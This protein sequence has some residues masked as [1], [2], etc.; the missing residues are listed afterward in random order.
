MASDNENGKT[1]DFRWE[2]LVA[3]LLHPVQVEIIEALWWIDRPL[4]ATD[5][6]R[7]FEGRRVGLRIEHHLRRLSKLDAVELEDDGEA[8]SA[9]MRSYRL[10]KGEADGC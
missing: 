10:V 8:H 9:A 3:R 7:V 4:S 5:L 1:G 6:L 2:T